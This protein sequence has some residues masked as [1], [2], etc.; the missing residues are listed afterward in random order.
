MEN[1]VN[2]Q[3]IA[4]FRD[5]PSTESYIK[6]LSTPSPYYMPKVTPIAKATMCSSGGG[7]GFL[8]VSTNLPR[9]RPII[10]PLPTPVP[11][12]QPKER[13]RQAIKRTE[14]PPVEGKGPSPRKQTKKSTEKNP[15]LPPIFYK[16]KY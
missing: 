7:L 4:S 16:Y 10:E 6:A 9:S 5:V 14:S 15:K 11:P 13:K 2:R 1:N 3:R 8:S 12:S